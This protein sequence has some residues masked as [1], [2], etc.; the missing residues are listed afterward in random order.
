ML[1]IIAL[2]TLMKQNKADRSWTCKISPFPKAK[3]VKDRN[4][5][6]PKKFRYADYTFNFMATLFIS[7]TI[8]TRIKLGN[9]N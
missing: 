1:P 9:Y 2:L 8:I 7:G 4:P 3:V 6:L 5:S